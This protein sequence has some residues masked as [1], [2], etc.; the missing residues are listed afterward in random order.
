MARQT[1]PQYSR[2][3]MIRIMAGIVPFAAMPLSNFSANAHPIAYPKSPDLIRH[4]MIALGGDAEIILPVKYQAYLELIENEVNRLE[5]IFSLYRNESSISKLNQQGF[6]QNPPSEMVA[7]LRIANHISKISDGGFDITIQP[8]WQL[9]AHYARKKQIAPADAIEKTREKIGWQYLRVSPN[10]IEFT[11]PDMAI[12]LNGIA[13]GYITDRI[14]DLLRGHGLNHIFI[15]MGEMR[16][17]GKMS[18]HRPWKV[19]QKI[20]SNIDGQKDEPAPLPAIAL[21]NHALATSE[22]YPLKAKGTRQNFAHYFINPKNGA[23]Q[24]DY[25]LI[26]IVAK[27]AVFADALSTA[28]ALSPQANHAAILRR[29]RAAQAWRTNAIN[30]TD[31][32][33]KNAPKKFERLI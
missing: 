2:R 1:D 13:Q 24:A 28:L 26:Q 5:N 14:A 12:S 22:P 8:L 25:R 29:G 19:N 30:Q 15:N 16:A 7:L 31:F 6:L 27:E 33:H 32:W 4:K 3:K 11:K 18:N 20:Y 17:L 21:D 23:V 9:H 10:R